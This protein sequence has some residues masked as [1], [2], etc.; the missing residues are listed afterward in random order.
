MLRPVNMPPGWYPDPDSAG[1]LRWW[2]GDSWTG[3][4][5]LAPAAPAPIPTRRRLGWGWWLFFILAGA[6]AAST[7]LGL[8]GDRVEQ[9][10]VSAE[11]VGADRAYL[12]AL[13]DFVDDRGLTWSTTSEVHALQVGRDACE[14]WAMTQSLDTIGLAAPEGD[15]ALFDFMVSSALAHLCPQ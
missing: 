13:H 8:R 9:R 7:L 15:R 4:R 11:Y 5:Q 12:E 10:P 1:V 6:L 2:T 3:A 14:V